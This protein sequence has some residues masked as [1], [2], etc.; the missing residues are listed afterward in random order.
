MNNNANYKKNINKIYIFLDFD[1]TITQNDL[2]DV[3]FKKY[4][5]FDGNLAKLINKDITIFDYWKAFANALPQDFECNGLNEIIANE[6]IDPYFGKF[7]ELC[8]DKDIPLAITTDNFDIITKPFL[9]A[10]LP[11]DIFRNIIEDN[12]YSNKLSIDGAKYIPQF[13]FANENCQCMSAVCKRNVILSSTP[14]DSIVIYVGDG[15]S[16]FCAAEVSDIIFAKNTLAK[17]CS[18]NRLPHYTY[19]SF[20]DIV[21]ILSKLLNQSQLRQRYQAHLLRKKA[22]ELE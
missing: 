21:Q 22:F 16:D 2:T 11:Q 14:D 15:F 1:G 10:K 6:Q 8:N 17:Y 9:Q 19:K 13:P 4:G 5:D 20:F 18:E 3:I 7:V 12:I